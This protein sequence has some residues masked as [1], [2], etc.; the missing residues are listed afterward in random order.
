[1]KAI[2]CVVY[3]L[4]LNVFHLTFKH[5]AEKTICL[6]TPQSIWFVHMKSARLT[7]VYDNYG[8]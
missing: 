3:E 4:L 2:A 5:M 8:Y 6:Q 7:L 1:M